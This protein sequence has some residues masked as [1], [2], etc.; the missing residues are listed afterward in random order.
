MVCVFNF[1]GI[2][3]KSLTDE[4]GEVEA[5]RLSLSAVSVTDVLAI[6]AFI[7]TDRRNP[8]DWA[9]AEKRNG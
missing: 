4:R 3:S 1:I 5:L 8:V 2:L 7:W 6:I 9:A